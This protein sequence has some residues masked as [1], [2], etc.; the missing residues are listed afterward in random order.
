MKNVR[1]DKKI[2]ILAQ[3]EYEDL[4]KEIAFLK[5]RIASLTALRDDL[6][7][8][9]CPALRSEYEEKVASLERE[10]FAA[11][12]Y[13]REKQRI[14]ELL[15]AR[16]NRRQKPSMEEAEQKA[17]VEFE[18][19]Q[20]DLKKKA[21]E[22]EDFQKRWKEDTGW[23]QH[24]QTDRRTRESDGQEADPETDRRGEDHRDEPS[25]KG[26]GGD[27]NADSQDRIGQEK[28]SAQGDAA[29][30]KTADKDSEGNARNES[31]V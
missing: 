17:K 23:Y 13:L 12:L 31:P 18:Q 25:G 28:D 10:L 20:E 6:I 29:E 16:I 14:I 1:F 5:D 9:V 7:Y 4:L 26:D 3:T 8:H 27:Q 11:Q 21:K 22:A 24:D 19:Y 15:Q 2:I 30:D